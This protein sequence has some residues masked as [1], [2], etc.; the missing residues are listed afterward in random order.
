MTDQATGKPLSGRA[1]IRYATFKDNP[2]AAAFPFSGNPRFAGQKE[3]VEAP[4][5]EQTHTNVLPDGTFQIVVLPGRG[6]V[7]VR[8]EQGNYAPATLAESEADKQFWSKTVPNMAQSTSEFQ[9]LKL[10]NLPANVTE[11]RAELTVNPKR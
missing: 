3:G 1:T 2:H 5:L 10:I 6:I 4:F 9:A 8:T 7:G 11:A